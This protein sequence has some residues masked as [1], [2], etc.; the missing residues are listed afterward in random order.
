MMTNEQIIKTIKNKIIDLT[1][2]SFHVEEAC[3][4]GGKTIDIYAVEDDMRIIK[5][6]LSNSFGKTR[7]IF[8]AMEEDDILYLHDKNV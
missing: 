3:D 4:D 2:Y 5:E 6:E 7:L 1:Y 8:Y